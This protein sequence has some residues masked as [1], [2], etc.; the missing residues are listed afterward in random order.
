M[1]VGIDER[2]ACEFFF[3]IDFFFGRPVYSFLYS[4]NASS[5]NT[6]IE[7]FFTPTA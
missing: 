1:Q 3:G 2:L 4:F 5:G 7:K 6:Y